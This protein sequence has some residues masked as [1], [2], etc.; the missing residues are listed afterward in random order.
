MKVTPK[1]GQVVGVVQIAD[2]DDDV[3]LVTDG[4]KLIRMGV[5]DIRVIGRQTQGVRLVRVDSGSGEKVASV[6]LVAEVDTESM[7]DQE[8][9]EEGD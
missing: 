6:A 8:T 9:P 3:V 4:G 2:V 5:G 1:T 7:D